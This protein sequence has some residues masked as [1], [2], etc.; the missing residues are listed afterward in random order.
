M[1]LMSVMECSRAVYSADHSALFRRNIQNLRFSVISLQKT[2]QS[3]EYRPSLY[4]RCDSWLV[5]HDST[6]QYTTTTTS[7]QARHNPD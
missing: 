4:S 1:C 6:L 5:L 7:Q 2:S 3:L